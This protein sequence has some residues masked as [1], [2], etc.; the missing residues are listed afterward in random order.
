MSMRWQHYSP[1]F[2]VC[3]DTMTCKLPEY[4]EHLSRKPTDFI[5]PIDLM[6][7]I[8]TFQGGK[9]SENLYKD[10]ST[11]LSIS[12]G[13]SAFQI[14]CSRVHQHDNGLRNYHRDKCA[15]H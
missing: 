1:S 12:G 3:V 7:I 15:P 5:F 11:V 14:G 9:V 13:Q 10:V 4:K 2:S 6:L 8:F